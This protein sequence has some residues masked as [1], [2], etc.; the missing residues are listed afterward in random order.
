VQ[1]DQI[2][3]CQQSSSAAAEHVCVLLRSP[4][5]CLCEAR[6]ISIVKT[7]LMLKMCLYSNIHI[8]EGLSYS[9]HLQQHTVMMYGHVNESTKSAMHVAVGLVYERCRSPLTI[10]V[11]ANRVVCMI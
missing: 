4:H 5:H 3:Q 1:A 6:R 10:I 11:G 7:L 8:H 9:I 2:F